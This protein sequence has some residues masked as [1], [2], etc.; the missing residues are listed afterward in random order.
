M[1]F[2]QILNNFTAGQWSPRMLANTNSEQYGRS[3]KTLQNMLVLKQ[4]GAFK[5]PGLLFQNLAASPTQ[6][7]FVNANDDL[8]IIP[9]TVSNDEKYLI[10]CDAGL[11]DGRWFVWNVATN[12]FYGY[13][14][15]SVDANY[16]N[17]FIAGTH[18]AQ[19]G[20][21]LYLTGGRGPGI[22]PRRIAKDAG[23]IRLKLTIEEPSLLAAGEYYKGVPYYEPNALGSGGTI[24]SSGTAGA[25]TLT[26][27]V[28][29]FNVNMIRT[30]SYDG[31]FVKLTSAAVTGV[32]VITGYTS[33]TQVTA[34]VIKLLPLAGAYG[35][36]SGTSWEISAWNAYYGLPIAVVAHSERLFWGGQFGVA[37]AD[38][39][40]VWGSQA[41]YPEYMMEIPLADAPDFSTYAADNSRA[42]TFYPTASEGSRVQCLA[43]SKSL[44]IGAEKNEIVGRGIQN[45]IGPND[46]TL[47]SST[48][49]GASTVQP[50]KA[51]NYTT[52]V[53]RDGRTIRD[54]VYSYENEQYKA[55]DINFFADNLFTGKTIVQLVSGV[56]NG[57]TIMLVRLSDGSIVLG[58]LD[59]EQGI[60]AWSSFIIGGSN[61]TVVGMA[62]VPGA[63]SDLSDG[64]FLLVRRLINGVYKVYLE[65]MAAIYENDTYTA[66][67]GNFFYY[68]DSLRI[69]SSPGSATISTPHLAGETVHVFGDGNY[70]GTK[71]ITAGGSL[72]LEAVYTE[73]LFGLG[74][75]SRLVPA[76]IKVNTQIGNSTGMAHKVNS[77][78]IKF[79][80]TITATYG[81]PERNEFYD[82]EFRNNTVVASTSIPL[83]S[84]EKRVQFPP[85]YSREKQVEVKSSLPFPCNVLSIVAE[86]VAY[87]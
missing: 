33:T 67:S 30:G 66:G 54:V 62:V 82:I 48:S 26:S 23:V 52:F 68:M 8:F 77:L 13:V 24:T 35:L 86:G 76:P 32:A 38:P 50:V 7:T 87:D 11:P 78:Y 15:A 3:C 69:V 28:A 70:L 12:A 1:K 31:T 16:A 63:N 73:V 79:W 47:D 34:V 43:A 75:S 56:L 19:V 45:A 85:G 39:N 53:Q 22:W 49:F 57:T 83:F 21:I 60:V 2:N 18:Y 41:G 14:A 36:A 71:V 20:D 59:R 6:E 84:G 27:S 17:L 4:G 40:V 9:W 55:V 42:F 51:D 37:T 65:K 5:R 64:I 61:V 72:V 81:D 46:I 80:N 29:I 44:F 58:S 25:I 10:F 74:Y